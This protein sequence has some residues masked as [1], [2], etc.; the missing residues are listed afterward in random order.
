MPQLVKISKTVWIN[1]DHIRRVVLPD[2]PLRS[3]QVTAMVVMGPRLDDSY[4]VEIKTAQKIIK[5]MA[6]K[7]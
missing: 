5:M 4:F 1:P 2:G 3:L 7:G 6:E